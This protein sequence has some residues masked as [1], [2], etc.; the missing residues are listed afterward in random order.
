[1]A[2]AYNISEYMR[3]IC[4]L[5]PL[6]VK[7][8]QRATLIKHYYFIPAICLFVIM[9]RMMLLINEIKIIPITISSNTV[10]A[11]LQVLREK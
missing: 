6:H 7:C 9:E 11:K 1:M 5:R 10:G 2:G 8:G 3:C 4:S